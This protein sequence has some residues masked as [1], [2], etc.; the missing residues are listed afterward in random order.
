MGDTAGSPFPP[1]VRTQETT[2]P[3]LARRIA[4]GPKACRLPGQPP[5]AAVR[6]VVRGHIPRTAKEPSEALGQRPSGYQP[7]PLNSDL[8]AIHGVDGREGEIRPR[9]YGREWACRFRHAKTTTSFRH[10]ISPFASLRGAMRA[11]RLV[12]AICF[13]ADNPV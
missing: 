13:S 9:P 5:D 2:L 3:L 6:E 11:V 7:V 4:G 1:G 12:A 8:P 10:F